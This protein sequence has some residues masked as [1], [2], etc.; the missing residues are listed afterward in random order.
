MPLLEQ[1]QLMTAR[2]CLREVCSTDAA[3]LY[4]VHSDPQVMRYWGYPAWTTLA[5]AQAKVADIARQR[6]NEPILVWAVAEAG[7]DR[8]IGTIA[9]FSINTV[10]GRAE[11]GYSLASAWHGRGLAREAVAAILTHAFQGLGL[12]RVEADI[13][14]RNTASRRLAE[15]FGFQI[16]GRLRERWQV[17]GELCDSLLYGLLA[18]DFRH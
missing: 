13:D 17:N 16:E 10:Q 4:A 2:L 11:I 14:P 3:D 7:S 12:R 9:L 5:Q 8:L 15:H 18:R 1:P 6:A